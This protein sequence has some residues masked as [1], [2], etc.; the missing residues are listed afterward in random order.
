MAAAQTLANAAVA[1]ADAARAQTDIS[2]HLLETAKVQAQAASAQAQTSRD[3]LNVE[4]R[5]SQDQEK[6]ATVTLSTD[7]PGVS[8]TSVELVGF[9]NIS[10]P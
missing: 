5:I 9:H 1:Q 2:S 6:L 7:K 10:F 3:L 4:G 8:T